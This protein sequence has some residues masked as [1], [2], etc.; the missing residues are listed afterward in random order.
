MRPPLSELYTV[1]C[2]KCAEPVRVHAE[3]GE[4]VEAARPPRCPECH[5]ALGLEVITARAQ[6]KAGP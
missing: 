6:M 2:P 5:T 3:I 1:V 4:K